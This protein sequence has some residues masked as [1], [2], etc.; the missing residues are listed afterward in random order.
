M[1]KKLKKLYI[2]IIII[3]IL[4]TAVTITF[5]YFYS[6]FKGK[7]EVNPQSA[8]LGL[9]LDVKKVTTDKKEGL[10]PV[11][12][13]Q[14]QKALNG[15]NNA[16]CVNKYG[17]LLCQVYKVTITNTGNVVSTLSSKINLYAVG[18]KS[19][20]TNLKWAEI[21]SAT[22]ATLFGRIHTMSDENWKTSFVMEPNSSSTFYILVWISETGKPQED[23]DYGSFSGT[24]RFDSTAGTST[25]ATFIG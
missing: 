17:Q 14:L 2:V 4:L 24:I 10:Y 22:D 21:N 13:N 20:F 9:K 3:A 11:E 7:S 15:T 5:S 18:Q 23:E 16:S 6:E 25:N 8:S 1:T 19:K 12:D